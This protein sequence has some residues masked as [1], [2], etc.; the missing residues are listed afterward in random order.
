MPTKMRTQRI[1][2]PIQIRRVAGELVLIAHCH[3]RNDR[4][5][6]KLERIVRLTRIEPQDA[7]GPQN[8]VADHN[9]S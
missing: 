8:L 7:A 3:L 9:P 6:F 4:R 5:N 1:V 2:D